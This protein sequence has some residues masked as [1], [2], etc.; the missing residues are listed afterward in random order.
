MHPLRID[1]NSDFSSWNLKKSHGNPSPSHPSCT[2]LWSENEAFFPRIPKLLVFTW[3]KETSCFTNWFAWCIELVN[4]LKAE[5]LQGCHC[6]WRISPWS[7]TCFFGMWINSA[8]DFF[9]LC[10]D[11]FRFRLLPLIESL[12]FCGTWAVGFRFLEGAPPQKKMIS[13]SHMFASSMSSWTKTSKNRPLV[14][15]SVEVDLY[16]LSCIHG[17][18]GRNPL[19]WLL[20]A[21][22][23]RLGAVRNC[24]WFRNPGVHQ[25]R[26]VVC[27]IKNS[28][29]WYTS[30]VFGLGISEPSTVSP[31][32]FLWK[33]KW[34]FGPHL[35]RTSKPE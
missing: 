8:H 2:G 9:T 15:F 17:H 1:P 30:Q 12:F 31:G 32:F 4:T 28:R 19:V 25:L 22:E 5:L 3:W 29:F 26:W 6:F 13:T 33:K 18:A 24:W 10:H 34:A 27:P 23:L 16:I 35:S 20:T 11:V 14:R 7:P 21:R